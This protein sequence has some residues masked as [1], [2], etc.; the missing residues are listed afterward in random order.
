VVDT[1]KQWVAEHKLETALGGLLILLILWLIARRRNREITWE[2]AVGKME[3]S[4]AVA[5]AAAI[6]DDE[7]SETF[8][9][10]PSE[11][12]SEKTVAEL[13]EQ[14]DMFV[15][16]ADYVQARTS[17]EQARLQ[18]PYNT[19]V[20]YKLL[21]VLYKQKQIDEFVALVEETQF[22][23]DSYE[24]DEVK[25]WGL[26]LLPGSELFTD[27]MPEIKEVKV[28]DEVQSAETATVENTAE[29]ESEK[30]PGHIAFD[31]NDFA[32][33]PVA[34]NTEEDKPAAEEEDD[35]LAFDINF[36]REEETTESE[37]QEQPLDIPEQPDN[38]QTLSF[39]IDPDFTPPADNDEDLAE[40]DLDFGNDEDEPDLEFDVGDLDDI[41]EAETKLDLA[42]AY[43]DMGDPDGAK[44]ILNEVLVEG[45]EEQKNRAHSL[46]DT[47]T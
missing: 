38:D 41:D 25:Q 32:D 46:L 10:A 22:D 45:N 2:E 34:E 47:L 30:E 16:Y 33:E 13:V 15:G 24:W 7:K 29:P 23:K 28:E 4:E 17:L 26:E 36:D 19:L 27:K 18:E 21:F 20:A 37:D 6:A 14:A 40:A 44:S 42:A 39:D 1:V 11:T 12:A 3:Q 8:T 31:L 9:D 43:I 5:P 35:L